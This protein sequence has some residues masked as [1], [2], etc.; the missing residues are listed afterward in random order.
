MAWSSSGYSPELESEDFDR[1]TMDLPAG[2]D[3]LIGAVA[4]ANPKT[5]VVV[6]AGAPV[7]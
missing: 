5:I 3:D 2:Q 7:T 6:V 4:A 1:K